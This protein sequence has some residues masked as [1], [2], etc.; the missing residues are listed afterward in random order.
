ME[1]EGIS[2]DN[3][4]VIA[5]ANADA[6]QRPASKRGDDD[7]DDDREAEEEDADDAMALANIPQASMERTDGAADQKH[8]KSR[9]DKEGK[10]R[11][12]KSSKSGKSG[13]S[14]R[15]HQKVDHDEKKAT[16][17]TTT[18]MKRESIL[19]STSTKMHVDQVIGQTINDA[20]ERRSSRARKVHKPF[21]FSYADDDD[22]DDDKNEKEKEKAGVGVTKNDNGQHG[23]AVAD[24]M[25]VDGGNNN[26]VEAA[27]VNYDTESYEFSSDDD[28]DM[29]C[30]ADEEKESRLRN[31]SRDTT[32]EQFMWQR[33]A[34]I[35]EKWY[36]LRQHSV[37]LQAQLARRLVSFEAARTQLDSDIANAPLE[38][39]ELL[40]EGS[41]GGDGLTGEKVTLEETCV[42]QGCGSR[43]MLCCDYCLEH[44]LNDTQQKLYV[45]CLYTDCGVPVLRHSIPEHR[46][47]K[48]KHMDPPPPTPSPPPNLPPHA[49]DHPP[50]ASCV[51]D[52]C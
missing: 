20:G 17:P 22:D 34:L 48:H 24:E 51:H 52:A 13:G 39:E 36:Q 30:A 47:K 35:A 41:G 19:Q 38:K 44:V 49:D 43:P 1:M 4:A 46:C 6:P 3:D 50:D 10:K 8:S 7:N 28:D 45:G 40:G 12:S 5:N 26:D 31:M 21:E 11:K 29:A 9:Q 23:N 32:L 18:K 42:F 27:A 25:M 14:A 15:K 2:N 37:R 33:E 16:V